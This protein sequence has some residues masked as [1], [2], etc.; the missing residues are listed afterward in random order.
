MLLT[1]PALSP[2]LCDAAY[3]AYA[4]VLP[5]VKFSHIVSIIDHL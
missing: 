3:R 4:L 2:A 5:V 1:C